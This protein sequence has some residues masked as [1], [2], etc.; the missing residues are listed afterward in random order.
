MKTADFRLTGRSPERVATYKPRN[1]DVASVT[2]PRVAHDV[3]KNS[4]ENQ[5]QATPIPWFLW[6]CTRNHG[7]GFQDLVQIDRA[8]SVLYLN[9]LRALRHRL[10]RGTHDVTGF[11]RW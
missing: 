9:D 4:T 10:G 8:C 11:S 2:W 3:S 1:F 7:D 6:K 5:H